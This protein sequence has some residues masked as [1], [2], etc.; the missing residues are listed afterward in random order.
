MVGLSMLSAVNERRKDIG[1]LRSLG[2]GKSQVFTIFCLE[3]GLIGAL[4]GVIG[5]LSGFG[6]S[7]KV[8]EFLAM[9]EGGSPVFSTTHLLIAGSAFSLVTI[10]AAIYPAWK[11][12][13]IDPSTALVAL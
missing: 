10:I 1:I 6:A 2:Y 13:G 7:F 9:A 3:A 8:L 5:Y 4:A 11:G 12:A